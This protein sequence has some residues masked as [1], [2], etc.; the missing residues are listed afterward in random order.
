MGTPTERVDAIRWEGEDG[1]TA[2]VTYGDLYR[3]TN[4]C[5]NALRALGVRKG[6]RVALFMPMTPELIAA[7]FAVMKIGGI[8]LPLFSGYGADAIAT[9]ATDAG[10]SVLITA[11][12]FHRRGQ[13]VVMKATAN[14]AADLAPSIRHVIVHSRL[15]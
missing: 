6:D 12:G 2:T 11:D 4:R 1:A 8:V 10:V 3:M 7:F 14:A 15:G 5:A 9:R 13:P